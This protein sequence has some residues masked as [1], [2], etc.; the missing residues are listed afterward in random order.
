MKAYFAAPIDEP[1]WAD[2]AAV[3]DYLVEQSR[4]Y[5]A[6]SV[7]YDADAVRAIAESVVDRSRDIAASLTNHSLVT[8]SVPWRHRLA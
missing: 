8:G 5:A 1:D 7:P 2:R 6:P 4:P 3:V